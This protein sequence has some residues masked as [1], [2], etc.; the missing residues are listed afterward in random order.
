VNSS[1]FSGSAAG[2]RRVLID[3]AVK[4]CA[5]DLLVSSRGVHETGI[6]KSILELLLTSVPKFASISD[7]R[8]LTHQVELAS[9]MLLF[10]LI[11]QWW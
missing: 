7:G 3:T 11:A 10:Y 5:L 2:E 4:I 1:G 9:L 8:S 6:T